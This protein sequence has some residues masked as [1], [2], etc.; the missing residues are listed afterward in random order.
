MYI[1]AVIC[2]LYE[3]YFIKWDTADTDNKKIIQE[4]DLLCSI[5]LIKDD[6]KQFSN[7]FSM[8]TFNKSN[9]KYIYIS[10]GQI[11]TALHVFDFITSII[12][13]INIKH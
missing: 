8:A 1:N 3:V 5:C 2:C 10:Q 4:K 12:T 7:S 13:F 9:G 6:T 11:E